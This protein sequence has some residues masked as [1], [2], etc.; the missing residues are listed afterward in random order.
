M[1]TVLSRIRASA[2]AVRGSSGYGARRFNG[3]RACGRDAYCGR[4]AQ[5]IRPRR[6]LG[7]GNLCDVLRRYTPDQIR[8]SVRTCRFVGRLAGIFNPLVLCSFRDCHR[9][10]LNHA[11]QLFAHLHEP[12]DFLLN[13]PKSL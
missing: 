3:N 8:Q 5:H 9:L 11:L 4:V 7:A 12:V 10:R 13:L 6:L 2:I 1:S